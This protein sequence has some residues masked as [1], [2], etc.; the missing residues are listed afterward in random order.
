MAGT[1]CLLAG[2]VWVA[3]A[4]LAG[5]SG[6]GSQSTGSG[7]TTATGGVSATGSGGVTSPAGT[8]GHSASGGATAGSGGAAPASGGITA[9]ASGGAG[10]KPA[11]AGSGGRQVASG[12]SAG[13]APATG[14]RAGASAQGGG[15]GGTNVPGSGG[16]AGTTGLSPAL[17]K[18]GET[19]LTDAGLTIVSYGGYLN[20]E[21]FQE[22]GVVSYAGYQY[23][24]FWNSARHVVVAR[25]A[26]PAG[27]W[28]RVELTDYTNSEDDAH[29]TISLG[30]CPNDNTLHLAF[31]H[32]G[33]TLLYRKSVSDLITHPD[34]AAWTASSFSAVTGALVGA[35]TVTQ[36][37]YPRFVTA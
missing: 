25:R 15:A 9:P 30:V 36:E 24:A 16:S 10:G 22:D 17:T 2:A 28:T 7:G 14:G 33:S 12:G 4:V 37:P 29:N 35:T 13:H 1:R 31:D 6:S 21:S 23:A 27:A 20:G 8:G 26:L 3:G 11:S 5:C 34:S 32:H 18:T 19:L